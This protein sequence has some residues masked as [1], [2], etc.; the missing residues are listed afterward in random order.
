MA[1]NNAGEGRIAQAQALAQEA[2]EDPT[3]WDDVKDFL[4]D[5]GA[6]DSKVKETIDYVNKMKTYESQFQQKSSASESDKDK[7]PT[8]ITPDSSDEHW[9]TKD[10]KHILIDEP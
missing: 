7:G 1:A 4:G 6:S 5:A 3:S 9:I 8:T 10:G 2:G